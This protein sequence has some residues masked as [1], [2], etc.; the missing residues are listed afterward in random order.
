[1]SNVDTGK[2][3]EFCNR[4]Q[5]QENPPKSEVM[6]P[7]LVRFSSLREENHEPKLYSNMVELWRPLPYSGE[8]LPPS[9]ISGLPPVCL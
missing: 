5:P 8:R 7:H 9:P 1:M 3:V 4:M 2:A 6:S